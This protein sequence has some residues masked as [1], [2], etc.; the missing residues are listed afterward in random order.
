MDM[1][2]KMTMEYEKEENTTRKQRHQIR[3]YRGRGMTVNEGQER[4]GKD[5]AGLV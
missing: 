5:M 3:E 4:K 2:D 1:D